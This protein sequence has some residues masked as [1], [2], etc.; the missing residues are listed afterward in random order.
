[1]FACSELHIRIHLAV[2]VK[3]V[4]ALVLRDSDFFGDVLVVDR[5]FEAAARTARSN[6]RKHRVVAF[7]CNVHGVFEPFAS[8]IV[9]DD[10]TGRF[11]VNI[12]PCTFTVALAVIA[13][14]TMVFGIVFAVRLD[15]AATARTRFVEVFHFDLARNCPCL[16]AKRFLRFRRSR[17]APFEAPSLDSHG[18][19]LVALE[20]EEQLLYNALE[21]FHFALGFDKRG[22]VAG[23]LECASACQSTRCRTGANF[24]LVVIGCTCGFYREARCCSTEVNTTHAEPRFLARKRE[25][26]MFGFFALDKVGTA[27]D[28]FLLGT[29]ES[30]IPIVR[31]KVF[32]LFRTFVGANYLLDGSVSI[33]EHFIYRNA[34][35]VAFVRVRLAVIRRNNF[36]TV[37]ALRDT[38]VMINNVRMALEFG[39]TMMVVVAVDAPAVHARVTK[40]RALPSVGTHYVIRCAIVNRRSALLPTSTIREVVCTLVL[41]DVRRFEH[42]AGR[43]VVHLHVRAIAHRSVL[44]IVQL[45]NIKVVCIRAAVAFATAPRH[46]SRAV[47]INED[48]RVKT[49]RDAIAA[50][51]ATTTDKFVLA[52][53]HSVF[54][55]AIN[56]G[57][58]DITDTAATA[59]REHDIERAIVNSDTRRPN[60]A[61]TVHLAG[62]VND[63]E[64]GPVLH[65]LATETIKS[66]NLV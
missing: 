13:F 52:L 21:S 66:K 22:L 10:V 47:V 4:F 11:L 17:A 37:V 44:G 33:V 59:I 3:V 6:R 53:A 34:A 15:F 19:I 49:P 40:D 1:M 8:L 16:A 60:S 18:R 39:N 26:H 61:D 24:N 48:A 65:I 56:A 23:I 36:Q 27:A 5:E 20:D 41:M 63:A 50:D 62:I 30:R 7:F 57:S 45:H 51:N 32:N 2:I 14:G 42:L 29:R 31:V 58:L 55:R 9:T 38:A 64:V 54:P 35:V 25:Q 28:A 12:N 43:Q 46:V